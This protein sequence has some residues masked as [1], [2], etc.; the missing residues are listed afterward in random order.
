[1]SKAREFTNFI[2]QN[3]YVKLTFTSNIL[4]ATAA[5]KEIY[6]NYIGSK[7]P[8]AKT[9][10]E[11]L[12]DVGLSDMVERGTDV[13]LANAEGYPYLSNHVIKGMF[14]A[15]AKAIRRIP[16]KKFH[17]SKMSAYIQKIEQLVQVY[18][19]K[20]RLI[21]PD[22]QGDIREMV[23]VLQRPL[24]ASTPQGERIALAS[25]EMIPEDSMIAFEL[26]LMDKTME[27]AIVEWLDFGMYNGLGQWRNGGYGQFEWELIDEDEFFSLKEDW[28]G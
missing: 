6:T 16:G 1:M 3:M 28:Q 24:R 14:K 27:P 21:P 8:D 13:F 19:R 12:E 11:E 2:E 9:L 23:S 4:G 20:L 18:P 15:N 22:N 25:S 10:Q 7:A 17:S 5:D 26:Q